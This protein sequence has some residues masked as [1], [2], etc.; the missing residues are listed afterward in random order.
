MFLWRANPCGTWT[1]RWPGQ[2][3]VGVPPGH[4]QQRVPPS[5]LATCG[6]LSGSHV[7][8]AA[9]GCRTTEL[10]ASWEVPA[11][12]TVGC[13]CWDSVHAP[14]HHSEGLTARSLCFV[15]DYNSDLPTPASL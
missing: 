4:T 11:S 8:A 9:V 7:A 2:V 10:Q 14:S 13:S 15:D 12:L 3:K 6:V 5:G 1:G